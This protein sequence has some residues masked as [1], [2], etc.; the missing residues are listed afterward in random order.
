MESQCF[1]LVALLICSRKFGPPLVETAVAQ[2]AHAGS[3]L[4]AFDQTLT[5]FQSTFFHMQRITSRRHCVLFRY[6]EKLV[7]AFITSRLDF[8]NTQ[9]FG[10]LQQPF[11]IIQSIYIFSSQIVV[12]S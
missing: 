12:F 2:G 8:C 1:H 9:F 5:D 4:I 11:Q 3:L 7:C 6:R 10:S